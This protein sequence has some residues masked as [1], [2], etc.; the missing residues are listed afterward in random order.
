MAR[1]CAAFRETRSVFL[2]GHAP[3]VRTGTHLEIDAGWYEPVIGEGA[4]QMVGLADNCGSVTAPLLLWTVRGLGV[5]SLE[6][7]VP[8]LLG[9]RGK[10]GERQSWGI[11]T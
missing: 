2:H 6:L 10:G 11:S 5:G 7:P 1:N 8:A 9:N 3:F 4:A